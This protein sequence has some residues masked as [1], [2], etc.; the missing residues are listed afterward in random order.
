M[1]VCGER[2]RGEVGGGFSGEVGGEGFQVKLKLDYARCCVKLLYTIPLVC[3][4]ST[5]PIPI[6]TPNSI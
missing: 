2:G 6:P 1:V 5:F 3:C 4:M